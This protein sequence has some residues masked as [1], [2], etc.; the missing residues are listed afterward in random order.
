MLVGTTK[1]ICFFFIILQLEFSLETNVETLE[2]R[3]N[4]QMVQSNVFERVL[5]KFTKVLQDK[6]NQE[7]NPKL[8]E[9]EIILMKYLLKKVM[10]NRKYSFQPVS[11]WHL[12]E[13]RRSI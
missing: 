8:N 4:Y 6:L 9:Q 11:Y 7:K 1:L 5:E 2:N 10:E 13:G 3:R 12:R